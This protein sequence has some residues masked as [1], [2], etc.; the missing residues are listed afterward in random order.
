MYKLFTKVKENS[1]NL[2]IVSGS[3][4]ITFA[5]I[6]V[7]AQIIMIAQLGYTNLGTLLSYLFDGMFIYTFTTILLLVGRTKRNDRFLTMSVGLVLIYLS[8]KNF[9]DGLVDIFS[10][11]FQTINVYVI[12]DNIQLVLLFADGILWLFILYSLCNDYLQNSTART[13]NISLFLFISIIVRSIYALLDLVGFAELAT[14]NIFNLFNICYCL[15]PIFLNLSLASL[16]WC[17]QIG[18]IDL[19]FLGGPYKDYEIQKH[20]K[21]NNKDNNQNKDYGTL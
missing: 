16:I 6:F 3:L 10:M 15:A 9:V 14:N 12:I 2:M 4:C 21:D 1:L 19:R 18:F 17:T 20:K 13:Y 5:L 11:N 8:V 7:I